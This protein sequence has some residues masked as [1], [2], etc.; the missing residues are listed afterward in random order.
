[1]F[2][3]RMIGA[4][5]VLFGVV[6]V[7]AAPSAFASGEQPGAPCSAP[8][9][10]SADG[11]LWC[12]GQSRIWMSHSLA[13]PGEPCPRVGDVAYGYGEQIVTCGPG[14]VWQIRH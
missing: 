8:G 7:G 13:K 12:S 6:G 2:V 1:M 9:A 4:A 3:Y 11:T 5:A 14:L 10:T